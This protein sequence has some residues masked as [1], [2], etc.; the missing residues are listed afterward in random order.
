MAVQK[1]VYLYVKKFNS[2]ILS[3]ANLFNSGELRGI[4]I[5]SI[6]EAVPKDDNTVIV[7]VIQDDGRKRPDHYEIAGNLTL[8]KA[9]IEN[10]GYTTNPIKLVTVYKRGSTDY[11]GGTSF[12]LNENRFEQVVNVTIDGNARSRIVLPLIT[13]NNVLITEQIAPTSGGY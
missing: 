8:M 9:D 13:K 7:R 10:T 1:T 3:E 4:N 11:F 5:D 6:L 12:L 2:T